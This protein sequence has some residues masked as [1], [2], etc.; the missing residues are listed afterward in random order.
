MQNPPPSPTAAPA[1]PPRGAKGLAAVIVLFALSA[2]CSG[3]VALAYAMGWT[4]LEEPVVVV[5]AGPPDSGPPD[6]GPPDT[7]PPDTGPPDAGPPDA[8]VPPPEPEPE[9]PR[10]RGPRWWNQ[11]RRTPAF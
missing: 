4:E 8:W 6:A 7:G 11:Q 10:G 5:D 2:V 9:R 1:P 3:G